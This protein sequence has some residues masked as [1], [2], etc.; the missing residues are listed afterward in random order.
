[1]SDQHPP[2]KTPYQRMAF[3]WQIMTARQRRGLAMMA[4]VSEAAGDKNWSDLIADEAKAVIGA[5]RSAG[6]VCDIIHDDSEG[7]PL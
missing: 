2:M 5:L 6:V 7:V 4:G 3:A 1:M